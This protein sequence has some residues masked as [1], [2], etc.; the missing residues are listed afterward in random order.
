MTLAQPQEYRERLRCLPPHPASRP[1]SPLELCLCLQ[2]WRMLRLHSMPWPVACWGVLQHRR[3]RSRTSPGGRAVGLPGSRRCLQL[4]PMCHT[5]LSTATCSQLLGA[6]ARCDCCRCQAPPHW[7]RPKRSPL[8]KQ[9][10]LCQLAQAES[11]GRRHAPARLHRHTGAAASAHRAARLCADQ[12][13]SGCA[14]LAASSGRHMP[15]RG[16]A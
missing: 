16:D 15:L 10:A 4:C 5:V 7:P 2:A 14:R 6:M 9:P 11:C 12:V 8:P 1:L 3:P 13:P